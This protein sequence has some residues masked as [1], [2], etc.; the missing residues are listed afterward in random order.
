MGDQIKSVQLGGSEKNRIAIFS[1]K[2]SLRVQNDGKS[3]ILLLAKRHLLERGIDIGG[4][5]LHTL[6][7]RK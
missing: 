2:R 7:L 3:I 6:F 1:L 4:S 5:S